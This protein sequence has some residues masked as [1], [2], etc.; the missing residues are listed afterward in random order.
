MVDVFPPHQQRQVR[1]QLAGVLR[2][3]VSQTLLP[4]RDGGR[5]VACEV[6]VATP[7]VRNL[8][9]EAKT[10]Q[11]RSAIQ[12]GGR[13]GMWTMDAALADLVRA[14]LVTA[15]EAAKRSDDP[16]ELRRLVRAPGR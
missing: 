12:T 7:A 4:R 2:G 10:H 6:L 9:R 11:I 16:E 1:A 3:V 13:F 14:G 15:G 8:I 5:V